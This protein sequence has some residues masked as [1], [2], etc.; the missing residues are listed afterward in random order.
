MA[1]GRIYKRGKNWYTDIIFQGQRKREKIGT[2]ADV[3]KKV[4]ENKLS[5]LTLEEHG[6]VEREDHL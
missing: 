2:R 6:I 4:L 1:W 3:A 5:E